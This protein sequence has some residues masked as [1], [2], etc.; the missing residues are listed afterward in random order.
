MK[1]PFLLTSFLFFAV[2]GVNAQHANLGIKGGLNVYNMHNDN[3]SKNDAMTGF[4]AGLLAHIHFT[5]TFALQP[6]FL[7]SRQGAKHNI[8][9]GGV[10]HYDL[11]YLNIP[12]MFQ[13]MFHNGFRLE[14][15]PQVGFLMK[16][17]QKSNGSE[18]DLKPSLFK[19]DF[20]LGIGFGYIQP[21]SGFGFDARYNAGLTDITRGSVKTTNMG[22]QLGLL[23]QMN[24]R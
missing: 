3:G 5:K 11:D 9:D 2:T 23:Y 19:T 21:K 10:A 15:G 20:S 4:H 16:A 18:T 8:T 22:F 1:V 17:R 24:H 7:Y 13:Y 6:E 12:V 14:A